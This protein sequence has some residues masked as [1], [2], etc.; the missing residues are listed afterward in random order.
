MLFPQFT[1]RYIDEEVTIRVQ[2]LS[3]VVIFSGCRS[4]PEFPPPQQ[5]P[6]FEGYKPHAAR[7]IEMGD[8]GAQGHFVRDISE[9][10][11]GSW[12]WALQRPAVRVKVRGDQKLKYT[13]DFTLPDITF[14]DTGPVTIGFFVNDH[15]LDRVRYATGGYQHF[16]KAVP[17]AW[18]DPNQ[19]VIVAAE[20]DKMWTSK[21]DGTRYGF[22]ISR[23]GLAEQ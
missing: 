1:T 4:V 11:D 10:P 12:R 3:I 5:R 20:I 16:E 13:I 17:D 14:K 22:I 23:M 8:P 15:L 21:E 9:E 7:V 2:W 19:E 6:A 18:V